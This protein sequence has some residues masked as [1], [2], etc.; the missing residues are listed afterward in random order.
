MVEEAA[1]GDRRWLLK[2]VREA[3]GELFG[4]FAGVD[5]RGLRWR[6]GRGEWCLKE[7]AGHL[8]DAERLY[9]R[10]IEVIA[11][12]RPSAAGPLLPHEPVD[13]LPYERDY[14]SEPLSRLLSE[15]EAA[16][17]ETFW[18]LYTL[19][20]ADWRR[21]GRHPYRGRVSVY[22]IAREL[23]EHD[24]QHLYQAQRLRKSLRER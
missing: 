18:I 12:G 5:E 15:Y 22:D 21:C 10:Q 11:R 14:R 4:Q 2:A 19:D 9:Q 7:I 6:P 13:V 20:E 3:T 1:A 16:R 23:H 17:E 24:L 8:R